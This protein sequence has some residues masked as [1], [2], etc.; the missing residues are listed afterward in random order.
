M[1]VSKKKNPRA[2]ELATIHTAKKNLGLDDD[3][4]RDLLEEWTGKRSAADLTRSER[5]RVIECFRRA[6]FQPK[7]NAPSKPAQTAA[8]PAVMPVQVQDEDEPLVRKAKALWI[9]LHRLGAVRNP[10]EAALNRF[11]KRHT[12]VDHLNWLSP[13]KAQHFIEI[14]KGW[15]DRVAGPQASG[16]DGEAS[17][18][19]GSLGASP[20]P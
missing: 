16:G 8:Q 12:G 7:P 19:A 15:V 13:S 20:T 3:Q 4:Y 14:L 2:R 11:C 9:E 17:P 6:G 18:G 5:H 1:P 10:S